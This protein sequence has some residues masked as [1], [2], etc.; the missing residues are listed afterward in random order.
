MVAEIAEVFWSST[1]RFGPCLPLATQVRAG[2]NR[3]G[4]RG[5][6]QVILAKIKKLLLPDLVCSLGESGVIPSP[7]PC[8]PRVRGGAATT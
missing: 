7:S 5:P 4:M 6:L 2:V 8:H 1:S 3:Q